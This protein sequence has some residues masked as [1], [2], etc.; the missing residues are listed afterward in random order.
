MSAIRRAVRFKSEVKASIGNGELESETRYPHW[1][2][3]SSGFTLFMKAIYAIESDVDTG[4]IESPFLGSTTKMENTSFVWDEEE[5][6]YPD[7]I[8]AS[9]RFFERFKTCPWP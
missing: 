8:L 9:C 4:G 1:M 6:D 5:D 3:A 2:G 7:G